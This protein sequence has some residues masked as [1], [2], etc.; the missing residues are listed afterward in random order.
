MVYIGIDLG[1]TNIA[2][3]VVSEAGSILAETSAKTLA[4]RPYK[5][6]VRDMAACVMKAV[7]KAGLTEADIYSIGIGIPGVAE[8]DNG[9]VFN[10]TNLGWI[11]VP[12]RDEMQKYINKP[13][14]IDN[15][16]NVAAL[17]E[18]Y[19]GVS[20]GYKSSVMITLGTGVGGGIVING[21]PWSG[22]HGRAGEIGHMTLVPDGAPCTCGNNGCV[23]RYCSATA[24][25]RT[26]KQECYSFPST[27]ILSKAGGNINRVN[28]KLVIDA[29]K[30]GDAS[31]LRVFNSFVK[32]LAMAI[33][34]ITAFFDPDIIVLGGGVSYAGSFLLDSVSALLPRYQMFKALP[35]P[36]LALA[37]L[38]N[39]AG[40]VGA[41]MLGK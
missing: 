10:C 35:I 33:N 39:E 14:F 1:G 31:A 2:V 22:A 34:N 26:A 28:A 21:K 36:K 37:K 5:E 23:E 40:I 8:G 18:S 16:A 25:I 6:I 12:L 27:A 7:T 3:G 15:D 24:I 29:A 4:E 9:V 38:G 19:F 11:N 32:Y 17:A 13:V 41:A 20:A 30:E